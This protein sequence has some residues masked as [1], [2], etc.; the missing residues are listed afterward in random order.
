MTDISFLNDVEQLSKVFIITK[1]II[2]IILFFLFL[3]LIYYLINIGNKYVIYR[4]KVKFSRKHYI[5]SMVIIILFFFFVFIY[6]F[7]EILISN[8]IPIL[9][10]VVFAYLLNPLVHKMMEYK[11]SRLWSV[12]ILYITIF[13]I[14]S[15]ASITIT[16]RVTEEIKNLIEVLPKYTKRANTFI[17]NMYQKY[18]LSM[19]SLPPEFIGVDVAL[20]DHLNKLQ[21]HIIDFL[22]GATEKG[23]SFFSSIVSIILI[24][25]Y[26]FYFLKDTNFFRKKLL[27]MIPKT[28]RNEVIYISKDVNKII[29]KF[30]RGQ[31]IIAA[32]VGIMSI[33]MLITLDV[34]FAFLIG[35]IAG[36]TNIIPYFGPIIGAVPGVIIALLD[37]PIKAFWVIVGFFIIQQIESV[38]L[39]P[40]IVGDSV[41]LHPVFVIIALLIGGQILGIAGLIFAIPIAA[42][43]K[44][45]FNHIN[46]I[47][48]KI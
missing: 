44:I 30:I 9:W 12:T 3:F 13:G 43:I 7:S 28:M 41:G 20:R 23:L 47:L 27:I 29:S 39:S 48:S 14:I 31:F 4:K 11:I 25:I 24:P 36:V 38:F 21:M 19:S 32:I 17:N 26:S 15:I 6:A 22:R 35:I 40:K 16:P 18:S 34:E 37:N 8:L 10:A 5:L 33:I 45:I 1:I 2:N 46:R 42:S